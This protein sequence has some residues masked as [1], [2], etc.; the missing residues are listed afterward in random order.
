MGGKPD[1]YEVSPQLPHGL[2]LDDVTGE[3]TGMPVL[4][5][6]KSLKTSHL[7]VAESPVG[8]T[9]CTVT[10]E[11]SWGA[12]GLMILGLRS[13]NSVT[14][15]QSKS[16]RQRSCNASAGSRQTE[17]SRRTLSTGQTK[18]RE[19]NNVDWV[20]S[21]EKACAVVERFGQMTLVKVEGSLR[22]V[23]SMSVYS[24]LQCLGLA[25]DAHTHQML[26]KAIDRAMRA[27]SE[28]R[29]TLGTQLDT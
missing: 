28:N 18:S 7:I 19:M 22:A 15:E 6:N 12:W 21:I 13:E 23:K 27:P 8:M 16:Q 17:M 20:Y 24:L 5:S 9:S 29:P 10:I 1:H 11:V 25:T 2:E 26:L 4:P 14:K 3:I